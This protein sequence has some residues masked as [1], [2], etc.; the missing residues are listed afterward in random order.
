MRDHLGEEFSGVVSSVTSFGIFVTLD[1]MYVEGLVHITELGG[2]YFRFDE[3]RQELCGE[4]SGL[5]Y[6]IGTRVQVQVSRVD[7]DGRRID[8]RLLTE[9][10]ADAMAPRSPKDRHGGRK[11]KGGGGGGAVSEPARPAPAPQAAHPAPAEVLQEASSDHQLSSQESAT[12]ASGR[13]QK[14]ALFSGKAMPSDSGKEPVSVSATQDEKDAG[15]GS[16]G[17]RSSK[18]SKTGTSSNKAGKAAQTGKGRSDRAVNGADK[19]AGTANGVGKKEA[20]ARSAGKAR[21]SAGSSA[22]KTRS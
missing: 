7:L 9:D 12:P 19:G 2:E 5:R 13:R 15:A 21:S 1:Q 4:R 6:A 17:H 11:S 20:G 22:R 18:G 8:F 10:G 3:A 16:N 14:A